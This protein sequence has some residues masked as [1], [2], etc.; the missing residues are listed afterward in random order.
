MTRR[1]CT[2]RS[3]PPSRPSLRGTARLVDLVASLDEVPVAD[4]F[5]VGPAIFARP[6][7]SAESEALLVSEDRVESQTHPGFRLVLEVAIA[8]EVLGVWSSW[9]SGA[10]PSPEQAVEAVIYYAENDAYLPA[11]HRVTD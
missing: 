3:R 2:R 10:T 9:R 11:A 1:A 7:W 8:R 4:R 5:E 6:P